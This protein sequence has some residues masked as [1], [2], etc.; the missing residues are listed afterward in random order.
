MHKANGRCWRLWQLAAVAA[1]VAS[2]MSSA[3]AGPGGK[4]VSAAVSAGASTGGRVAAGGAGATAS[5]VSLPPAGSLATSFSSSVR[6]SQMVRPMPAFNHHAS[7]LQVHT[8]DA[9]RAVRVKK[10]FNAVAEGRPGIDLQRRFNKPAAANGP[11]PPNLGF[12]QGAGRNV[13][14]PKDTVMLRYGGPGG[15]YLTTDLRANASTL[16]LPRSSAGAPARYYKTTAP[17]TAPTGPAAPGYGQPGGAT[18][19]LLS[20]PIEV[21][22]LR[23]TIAPNLNI[24]AAKPATVTPPR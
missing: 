20:K 18:Q 10:R 5:R 3:H 19:V 15:S 13:T 7:R 2:L 21:S 6:G 1:A 14:H 23:R 4:A 9:A 17:I 12:A 16:A 11:Y 24:A 22:P 8:K